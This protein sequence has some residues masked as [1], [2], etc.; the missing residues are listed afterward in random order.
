MT[1]PAATRWGF[2]LSGSAVLA[3]AVYFGL[4]S[5]PSSWD[6]LY[7]A[8][9]LS[10][11]E[12]ER[13]VDTLAVQ[14][15]PYEQ[16]RQ[17]R[18]LV[19]SSRKAEARALLGKQHKTPR[20]IKDV[21]EDMAQAPSI[22]ESAS[23]R[24]LRAHRLS[25][26]VLERLIQENPGVDSATVMI[27][28]DPARTRTPRSGHA[29]ALIILEAAGDGPVPHATLEA[30]KSLV[31]IREPDIPFEALTVQ[32]TKG[33][34]Y[35][36]AGNPD[37]GARSLA[38]ARVE[39]WEE[40]IRVRLKEIDGIR[41][42]VTLD[43]P[44][45]ETSLPPGSPPPAVAVNAPLAEVATAE[46][47][48]T[49]PL[50]RAMVLVQVPISY[51]VERYRTL[52]KVNREPSPEDLQPYVEKAE[53]GIKLAVKN[54]VPASELGEI[55]ISRID[56]PGALRPA[57]PA[58][59]K[60]PWRMP[61]WWM[62]VAA[63]ASIVAAALTAVGGRWLVSRRPATIAPRPHIRPPYSADAPGPSERV[64]E[65]VRRDPAAAAGV[66]HRWIGGGEEDS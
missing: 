20:T 58:A 27:R 55:K 42:W 45:S 32:D 18:I 3:T 66:L 23:E 35:L 16:D 21:L 36:L 1:Q 61:V 15:V 30:I 17:G 29:S 47:C 12:A 46:V 7:E 19:P 53:E 49:L 38:R 54:A 22:L 44:P 52:T 65:L 41:V 62:G 24:E 51:Y 43:S 4:P 39:D 60:E 28:R 2:L 34:I 26:E 56:V 13:I 25:E 31:P 59:G 9:K 8:R 48:Q 14:K 5:E 33:H 63:A 10:R 64:R 50:G 37:V 11:L 40:K 57:L 6:E